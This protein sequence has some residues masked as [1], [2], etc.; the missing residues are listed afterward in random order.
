MAEKWSV[1]RSHAQ[2]KRTYGQ[3][4]H[5]FRL[6]SEFLTEWSWFRNSISN[7]KIWHRK[8]VKHVSEWLLVGIRRKDYHLRTQ[9]ENYN[10]SGNFEKDRRIISISGTILNSWKWTLTRALSSRKHFSNA[11]IRKIIEK[12]KKGTR[13]IKNTTKRKQIKFQENLQKPVSRS[14]KRISCHNKINSAENERATSHTRT[15]TSIDR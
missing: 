12:L 6:S 14:D 13:K 7:L 2:E 3:E 5:I 11:K 10:K 9:N 15:A 4:I 1:K 8:Q